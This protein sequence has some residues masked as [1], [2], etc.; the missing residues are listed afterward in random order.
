MYHNLIT[1]F[2]EASF[3]VVETLELVNFEFCT[4][5]ELD[6][7]CALL[8]NRNVENRHRRVHNFGWG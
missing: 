4:L 5:L 6:E 1:I 2:V 8:L 7:G 3:E